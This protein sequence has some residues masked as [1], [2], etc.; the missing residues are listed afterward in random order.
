VNAAVAAWLRL[1]RVYHKVDR[2]SAAALRGR[3]LSV[4]QFDV[5]A[6]VGAHPGITQQ[7]LADALLVTKGN[8]C[9]ILDR[10]EAAGRLVRRQEGRANRVL[11]TAAGRRLHDEAVPAQEALVA[12]QMA[13]LT[14]DE[15]RALLG[16]LRKLDRALTW[17][18]AVGSGQGRAEASG[19]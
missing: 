2:A 11:L 13:A 16:L 4:A 10:L 3:G 15:Q 17:S 12:E 6:Q 18:A 1:A 9:Q 19:W 8:V 7:E 14:P 5:L